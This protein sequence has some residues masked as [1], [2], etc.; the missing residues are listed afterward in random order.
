M[1]LKG[2]FKDSPFIAQLVVVI[3]LS[4]IGVIAA[5]T[6]CSALILY[7]CGF[8]IEAVTDVLNHQEEYPSMMRT[9]QFFSALGA[10]VFPAIWAGYLFSEDKKIY[11]HTDTPVPYSTLVWTV[12]SM[13]FAIPVL[14]FTLD[15]NQQLVLPEG[16]KALEEW[17]KQSEEAMAKATEAMMYAENLKA[18]LFNIIIIAV[19]AGIGEEFMFR[20][21]LQNIFRKA[22]KN[23]HVVIWVVAVIFSAIH[24]Q[25]YGFVPR[26]LMGAYFG[27]LL[28]YTKSIWVPVLAHFTNN[29]IGVMT[30]YYFQDDIDKM[31]E[32]DAL[33]T[34]ST[35][36]LAVA[37]IALWL[38][39]F[40]QIQKKSGSSQHLAS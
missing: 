19:F 31:K 34:G 10:F 9:I 20:G 22:I 25:F 40:W 5:M 23:E 24:F 30:F 14:N 7:Q 35:W 37:S 4:F 26:L 3:T 29:F 8:S 28:Y 38:W 12:L 13:V 21:V 11:L 27:Y 15:L 1:F 2:V 39:A 18:L 36:W 6:I 16:L 33:G 17:M 32:M